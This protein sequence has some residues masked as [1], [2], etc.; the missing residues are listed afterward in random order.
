MV[1]A[2]AVSMWVGLYHKLCYIIFPPSP[3]CSHL[4]GGLSWTV[5]P[6]DVFPRSPSS[7]AV[8]GVLGFKLIG[9]RGIPVIMK[10]LCEHVVIYGVL[11]VV[12][13]LWWVL[14]ILNSLLWACVSPGL[15]LDFL[16]YILVVGLR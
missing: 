3:A 8:V 9:V 1:S 6:I 2:D 15:L 5:V 10:A 14:A 4:A 13:P 11:L 12:Q 7:M 16:F